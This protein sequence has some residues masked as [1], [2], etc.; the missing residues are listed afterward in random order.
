MRA[1]LAVGVIVGVVAV[2]CGAE[3]EDRARELVA[4]PPDVRVV[5]D[6]PVTAVI[7]GGTP[8]QQRLLRDILGG[9]GSD[10]ILRVAIREP[11]PD[12]KPFDAGDVML[13][14]E[15]ESP[16]SRGLRAEWETWLLAAAFHY[17]SHAEGLPGVVWL[18]TADGGGFRLDPSKASPRSADLAQPGGD[19]DAVVQRVTK[20]AAASGAEVA[21][22]EILEPYG[23][24]P[25]ITLR[26]AD[27]AA[28][29]HDRLRGFLESFG[30]RWERWEGT[31]IQVVDRAGELVWYTAGSSRLYHGGGGTVPEFEGCWPYHGIGG[32]TLDYVPPPC[33]RT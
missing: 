4:P 11:R 12:L 28:F 32:G 8:P 2:G 14:V 29:L 31:L 27:P 3:A 26:V 6:A 25:A 23:L 17:R 30:D 10:R 33:P 13:T 9:L 7:E 22:I 18:D 21:R 24:A 16:R 19:V 5:R 20:A 1:L 15:T